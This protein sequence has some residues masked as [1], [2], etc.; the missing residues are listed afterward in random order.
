[1]MDVRVN[2]AFMGGEARGQGP[3]R[4]EVSV[5]GDAELDRIEIIRD[6]KKVYAIQP[7]GK[8]HKFSFLDT[9]DRERSTSY[10]YVRVLQKDGMQAWSSPVWIQGE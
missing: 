8:A 7:H 9:T 3:T 6:R 1:M 4:I 5:S 2:G 10:Y